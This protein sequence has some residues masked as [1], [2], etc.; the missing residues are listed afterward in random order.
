LYGHRALK[1]FFSSIE[2]IFQI[3]CMET[4]V[5]FNIV[6]FFKQLKLLHSWYVF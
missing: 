4:K 2:K 5:H 3:T 1:M 6:S